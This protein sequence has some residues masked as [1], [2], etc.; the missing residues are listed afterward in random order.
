[1]ALRPVGTATPAATTTNSRLR[2]VETAPVQPQTTTGPELSGGG[3]NI[4][5]GLR[6]GDMVRDIFGGA[7]YGLSASMLPE[8]HTAK[9]A[10]QL[11]PNSTAEYDQENDTWYLVRSSGERQ[12]INAPGISSAD[13]MN[14]AA[15]A[16]VVGGEVKLLSALSKGPAAV[17]GFANWL[18]NTSKGQAVVAGGTTAAQEGL[19]DVAAGQEVDIPWGDVAFAAGTGGVGD[20]VGKVVINKGAKLYRKAQQA[21]QRMFGGT[22]P[23]KAAREALELAGVDVST[24]SDEAIKRVNSNM[25]MFNG[26]PDAERAR[27]AA[28]IALDADFRPTLGTITQDPATQMIE[29]TIVKGGGPRDVGAAQLQRVDQTNQ[30][31]I[32]RQADEMFPPDQAS[33]A[34]AQ[35]ELVQQKSERLGEFDAQFQDVRDRG[36]QTRLPTEGGAP[37][38]TIITDPD[39]ARAKAQVDAGAPPVPDKPKSILQPKVHSA[40][41]KVSDKF[42]ADDIMSTYP[43]TENVREILGWMQR[44]SK[45]GKPGQVAIEAAQE[46]LDQMALDGL[47]RGD[48][49]VVADMKAVRDEYKG[50]MKQWNAND[51]FGKLTQMDNQGLNLKYSP[52]EITNILLNSS[53]AGWLNKPGLTAAVKK[54]RTEL[55][56]DS[57]AFTGI[58]NAIG[59]RAIGTESIKEVAEGEL[60]VTGG[61]M[62]KRYNDAMMKRKELME[63]IFTP[64]E[65]ASMNHL[66]M[67]A[68]QIHRK[69]GRGADLNSTTALALEAA[70]KTGANLRSTEKLAINLLPSQEF[71]WISPALKMATNVAEQATAK[72]A[73]LK[74]SKAVNQILNPANAAPGPR[75]P[76]GIPAAQAPPSL[77][78]ML[79]VEDEEDL[80]DWLPDWMR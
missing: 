13:F 80:F 49:D 16:S 19:G 71:Q 39:I 61:T 67:V 48:A 7:V 29:S 63:S 72:I 33:A 58:K 6:T 37:S 14:L 50:F 54:L 64:E 69:P 75:V 74:M 51:L 22:E 4:G 2:P 15:L 78:E 34:Q 59:R 40:V 38:S 32:Q 36:A 27:A 55:G 17:K 44:V 31:V 56:A 11:I 53:E 57:E 25:P 3:F 24:L 26:Y 47:L 23:T 68:D 8:E 46:N 21:W 18:A 65:L 35:A 1:M 52:E 10:T 73:P 76:L 41:E 77:E 9:L 45:R 5:A 60:R 66:T 30:G 70:E 43:E 42:T 28:Q 79:S 12:P 62:R 20:A